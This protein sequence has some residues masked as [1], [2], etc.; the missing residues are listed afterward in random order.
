[1]FYAS[2]FHTVQLLNYLNWWVMA[3]VMVWVSVTVRVRGLLLKYYA[4]F[5][6]R[7]RHPPSYDG[8][9]VE[10]YI[11]VTPFSRKVDNQHLTVLCNALE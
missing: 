9:D 7:I 5:V 6:L 11:S 4:N 8:V 1:M 10:T 2:I 3:K